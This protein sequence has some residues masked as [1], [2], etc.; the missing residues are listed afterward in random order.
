MNETLTNRKKELKEEI[1][2]ARNHLQ[3]NIE[4]IDI[5]EYLSI[6]LKPLQTMSKLIPRVDLSLLSILAKYYP[7]KGFVVAMIKNIIKLIS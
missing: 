6:R 7:G 5:Q 2:I 3:N 1:E 4:A